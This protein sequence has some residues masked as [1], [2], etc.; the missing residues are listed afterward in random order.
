MKESVMDIEM[1]KQTIVVTFKDNFATTEKTS[2]PGSNFQGLGRGGGLC[3]YLK[4][5]SSEN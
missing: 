1:I 3:I 4:G 5:H 2:T